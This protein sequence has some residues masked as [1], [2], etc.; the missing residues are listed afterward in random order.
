M[1]ER[2][3]S[4]DRARCV[5]ALVRQGRGLY[6]FGGCS[7]YHYERLGMEAG[8]E[9]CDVPHSEFVAIT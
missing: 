2:A 1:R 4:E 3:R 8:W 7:V 5:D 9:G 6:P